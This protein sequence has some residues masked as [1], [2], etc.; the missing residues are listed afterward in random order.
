MRAFTWL[1][2]PATALLLLG[3]HLLHN[4]ASVFAA[5]PVAL[6]ALLGVRRRWVGRLVQAVLLVAAL[7]WGLTAAA[8]AQMR[9][10]H[11]EPYV[12]LVL[13]LGSVALFTALAALALQSACLRAW[14]RLD[15]PANT[16]ETLP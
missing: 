10:G 13:I 11:G 6:I 8:L 14:F 2:L 5:L 12:R 3:A 1:M 4:G 15:R 7:E 9:A 16:E